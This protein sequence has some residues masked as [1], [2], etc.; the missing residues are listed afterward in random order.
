MN[1]GI[2]EK[3]W[4]SFRDQVGLRD[5]A[6]SE[7]A[8]AIARVTFYAGAAAMLSALN[9]PDTDLAVLVAEIKSVQAIQEREKLRNLTRY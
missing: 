7:S 1:A 3:E 6:I 9:R 8:M 4:Q 5:I 2:L